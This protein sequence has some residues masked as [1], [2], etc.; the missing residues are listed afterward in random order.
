MT[1]VAH[2]FTGRGPQTL[3]TALLCER[4]GAGSV[5]AFLEDAARDRIDV[6]SFGREVV[7]ASEDGDAVAEG[8]LAGAG[9]ALGDT[10]V[11]VIRRLGLEDEA[12][13][14]VLA[15]GMFRAGSEAFVGALEGVVRP[16]APRVR[17]RKLDR[18]PVVGAALLAV[19][20]AGR[21]VE[22]TTRRALADEI[23]SALG[24]GA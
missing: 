23:S 14:L 24:H 20:L 18:P 8:I 10:A 19:E 5:V 1:A 3:L 2:A 15:G 11:H 6:T 13:D 21:V 12:F 4:V 7:R 22:P 17:L 9:G 16:A